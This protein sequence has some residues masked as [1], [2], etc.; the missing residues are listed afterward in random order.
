[1]DSQPEDCLFC[2]ISR[3]GP[4]LAASDGFVAVADIHPQAPVHVLVIPTRHVPSLREID[5]FSAEEQHQMLD[6]I[7]GTAASLGLEDFR[8]V[9]NVGAGAGQSVFHLHWHLLGDPDGPLGSSL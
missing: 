7:V 4:H 6:F 8:V 5:R 3:D 1:M 9:A 2:R